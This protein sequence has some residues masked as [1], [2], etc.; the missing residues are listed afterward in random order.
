[1]ARNPANGNHFSLWTQHTVSDR[2]RAAVRWYEIDLSAAFGPPDRRVDGTTAKHGDSFVI[3]YNRTRGPK[4]TQEFPSIV[5]GS[6][7]KGG[8]LV[9]EKVVSGA[10]AYGD[11]FCVSGEPCAWNLSASCAPDP[12]G[13]TRTF[14]AVWCTNV[15][16]APGSLPRN[17]RSRIFAVAP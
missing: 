15:Y 2:G 5:M 1:V 11:P 12:N 13:L 14:G 16:A 10:A 7:F 3:Q 8:P 6:S 9:T 4:G 17:W